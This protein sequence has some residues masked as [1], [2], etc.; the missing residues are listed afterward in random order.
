[1][2]KIK[3]YGFKSISV[4]NLLIHTINVSVRN[5]EMNKRILLN[6]DICFS[7]KQIINRRTSRH[8]F[9]LEIVYTTTDSNSIFSLYTKVGK[10]LK[11]I[12]QNNLDE[13]YHWVPTT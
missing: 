2:S 7:E 3:I 4:N 8:S 1:M 6:S 10:A 13:K 9:L 11:S 12:A 5:T